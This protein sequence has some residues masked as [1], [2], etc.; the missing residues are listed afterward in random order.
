MHILSRNSINLL[1]LL[2]KLARVSF[3]GCDQNAKNLLIDLILQE[4]NTPIYLICCRVPCKNDEQ[5]CK[6]TITNPA[7]LTIQNPAP[8]NLN[9]AKSNSSFRKIMETTYK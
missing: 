2:R 6:C 8:S 7:F 9:E 3:H 5:V 1:A 4:F